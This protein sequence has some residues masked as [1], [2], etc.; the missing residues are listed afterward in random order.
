LKF[1]NVFERDLNKKGLNLT[2]EIKKKKK[3]FLFCNILFDVSKIDVFIIKKKLKW[4][5]IKINLNLSVEIEL[6][7]RVRGCK[8]E[9]KSKIRIKIE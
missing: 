7:F 5:K 8:I 9:I 6:K 1:S 3:R 2:Q 4:V